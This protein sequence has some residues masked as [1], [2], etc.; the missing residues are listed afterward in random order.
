MS[1]SIDTLMANRL[2]KLERLEQAGPAPLVTASPT[3]SLTPEDQLA[4]DRTAREMDQRLSKVGEWQL[5]AFRMRHLE[6]LSIA[7]ICCRVDRSSD[8]VRSGLYRVKQ[9]LKNAGS[10]EMSGGRT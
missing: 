10:V 8:A 6:D 5:E 1:R 2:Q 7:E 3:W 9:M 4:L